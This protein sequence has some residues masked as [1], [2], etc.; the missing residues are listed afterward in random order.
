MS[1]VNNK[2]F[3]REVLWVYADAPVAYH[4]LNLLLYLYQHKLCESYFIQ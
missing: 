1:L 3:V 2:Y 4:I